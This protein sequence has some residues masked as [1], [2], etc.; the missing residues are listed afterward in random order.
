[1]V[2][3]GCVDPAQ[4]EEFWPF[5]RPLI[6]KAVKRTNLSRWADQE[7]S[8]LRGDQLLWLAHTG[9]AI[10]SAATTH[11]TK[12]EDG[13]PICTIT[14][15]GGE[16]MDQWLPLIEGI[17]KYARAEGCSCVRIFG[18]KGWSRVLEKYTTEH[19]VLER[20]F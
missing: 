14:A 5:A 15:C 6:E 1:M 7:E 2:K 16:N 20:H 8:I 18:R 4:I 13:R 17:E 19:V 10:Q 9:D 3:L 12:G 11:L